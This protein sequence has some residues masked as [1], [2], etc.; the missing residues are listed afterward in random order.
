M[1]ALL[2][3]LSH[4]PL[5]GHV[6][7]QASIVDETKAVIRKLADELREFDPELIILFAP[8]HY[9]GFFLDVMPQVCIGMAAQSIGDY[10]TAAGPLRVPRELAE[11]CATYV[12]SRDIDLALSYRMQVDHGFAQPLEELTG[13]LTTYPV[14]PIFINSA[15]PPVI[16]VRRAKHVGEA[17]GAFARS[18]NKR[19]LFMG[20]GGLSHNPPVPDITTAEPELAERIISGRN[21]TAE[22]VSARVQR[23]RA[24]AVRF[25]AGPS[26]LRPLNPA[27]DEGLLLHLAN[28]DWAAIDAYSNAAISSE[29][30]GSAHEIKTLDCCER[31][32]ERRY[33][34]SL[35]R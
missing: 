9:N 30:G 27:W 18:L 19:V 4:T 16:S 26:E 6:D 20:S 35:R 29:G 23:T 8:D 22:A 21:P 15:S 14:I 2:Q 5:K 34:G 1:K 17:I 25:A 33:L 13:S 7:P 28:Q 10:G 11:R 12:V 32:N 24:A 31:C 3:C